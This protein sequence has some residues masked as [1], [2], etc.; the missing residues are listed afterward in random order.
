M[1]E[2]VARKKG[3]HRGSS[4]HSDLYTA[5]RE[6]TDFERSVIQKGVDKGY[7]TFITKAA[8]GRGVTPEDIDEVGGGRVWS[9][10]QAL[11]NGLVDIIGNFDDAIGLAAKMS[12]IEGAYRIVNYPEQKSMFDILLDVGSNHI[13][14][15]S[16][17][18]TI[19]LDLFSK[20]FFEV[21]FWVLELT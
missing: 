7:Q 13:V 18:T 14:I 4:S 9:G 19:F 16:F 3:Q 21:S 2:R 5:T 15:P 20:G 6:L 1:A 11:D 17:K 10:I 12:D 8:N